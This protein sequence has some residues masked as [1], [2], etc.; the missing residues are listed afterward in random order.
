VSAG[1]IKSDLTAEA[2][3][4]AD[5]VVRT[6]LPRKCPRLLERLEV[7]NQIKLLRL[8]QEFTKPNAPKET[9]VAEQFRLEYASL[10]LLY[11]KEAVEEHSD[12][13]EETDDSLKPEDFTLGRRRATL[14]VQSGDDMTV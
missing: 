13:D 5:P 8:G 11:L 6:Q 2:L 10:T 1:E 14:G 9:R 12:F 7:F 3:R 4:T